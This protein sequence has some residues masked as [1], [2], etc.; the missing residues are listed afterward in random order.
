MS[1]V[2]INQ[3][4]VLIVEGKDALN[5]FGVMAKH[6]GRDDIQ[7]LD[8]GGISDLRRYLQ[9][10]VVTPGWYQVVSLGIIRDAETDAE[11]AVASVQGAITSAGL[12]V[13][14]TVPR[15]SLLVLPDN[16]RPGMLETLLYDS[17]AG[18]EIDACLN[19]F[20]SCC[21]DR[22]DIRIRR[23]AKARAHAYLATRDDP[24]VSI[25]VAAQKGYWNLDH[26]VF[27]QVRSFIGDL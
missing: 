22:G 2:S 6:C 7:V 16:S 4:H 27:G 8:F 9:A 17:I 20:F 18:T 5:F 24:H 1:Q 14:N 3:A 23:P 13:E 19:E 10:L 12:Q 26:E 15:V 25:G 11:S 21:V